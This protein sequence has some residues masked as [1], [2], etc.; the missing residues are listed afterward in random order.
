[1]AHYKIN[2]SSNKAKNTR[3]KSRKKQAKKTV[4]I[5]I[6]PQM[7]AEARKHNLN[8]SLITEQALQSILEYIPSQTETESSKYLLNRRSFP[9]ESRAG[10]SV[11]YDRRL[12]KAEAGG[13]NP[14]RST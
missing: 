11:W 9:K 13:S 3:V 14:P 2:H 5:T 12:R 4:G 7:L 10:R 1:M 8:I 6:S